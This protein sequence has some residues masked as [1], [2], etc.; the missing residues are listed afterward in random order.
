[1][2]PETQYQPPQMNPVPPASPSSLGSPPT[3]QTPPSYGQTGVSMSQQKKNKPWL[4][5]IFLML[6][7]VGFL[8]SSGFALW[9]YGEMNKYKKDYQGMVD[10]AVSQATEE[11]KKLEERKYAEQS[12]NPHLKYNG[13]KT[14]GSITFEYP[15]TWSAMVDTN[16]ST[17]IDGY[18]HEGIIPGAKSGAAFAL[19]LEV[20]DQPYDKMLGN[21][22]SEV[23]KGAVRVTPIK[24]ELVPEVLGARVD[25]EVGKG[26]TREALIGSAVLFPIRDKTLRISTL[27][28]QSYGK[29]FNEIVLKTLDFSP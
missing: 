8:G 28:G 11:T 1:M 24:A 29:D 20:V 22:D 4:L 17:P 14:F 10:S 18:F 23:K 12:K 16:G 21:Y 15:K 19:R 5:I 13:P 7:V 9:A 27:S 2:N 6:F 25:G 26:P 3:G